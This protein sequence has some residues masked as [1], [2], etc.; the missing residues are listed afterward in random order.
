MNKL[1]G[2]IILFSLIYGIISGRGEKLA[3]IILEVPKETLELIAS[4]KQLFEEFY[5]INRHY[6]EAIQKWAEPQHGMIK[7]MIPVI[8]VIKKKN[9]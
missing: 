7:R 1:W 5:N 4:N 6:Y 9:K 2:G 3:N 8:P